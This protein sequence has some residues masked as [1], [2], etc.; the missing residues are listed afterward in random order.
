MSDYTRIRMEATSKGPLSVGGTSPIAIQ[1]DKE[2]TLTRFITVPF[3]GPDGKKVQGRYMQH[4]ANVTVVAF[5]AGEASARADEIQSNAKNKAWG[6]GSRPWDS[7][8]RI[9]WIRVEVPADLK[10]LELR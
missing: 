7:N 2:F 4:P 5:S 10:P 6:N 3:K 9:N 1:P 8:D